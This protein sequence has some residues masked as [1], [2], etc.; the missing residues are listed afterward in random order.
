MKSTRMRQFL[1]AMILLVFAIGTTMISNN[2]EANHPV[3]VEGNNAALFV[4]PTNALN[5]GGVSGDY[6]GDGLVG[7]AEDNDN[8]SDRIF[9]TLTAAFANLNGTGANQ[10]GHVIIV[11]SGRFN[12][13]VTITLTPTTGGV[14]IVE[15]APGVQAN[16][17]AVLQ[18]E[19]RP[20]PN[21]N[22][23][24][25]A[26]TGI[27]INDTN[28]FPSPKSAV[29]RNL[30]IR[31]WQVGVRT[32]GT[33][34]VALDSCRLDSNV[35]HGVLVTGMGCFEATDSIIHAGGMRF[36]APGIGG[37]NPGN[38]ITFQDATFGSLYRNTITGNLGAGISLTAG[39]L[40]T[41]QGNNLFD[42]N[43]GNVVGGMLVA[44]PANQ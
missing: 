43:A 7:T 5:S 13:S 12:E 6:D 11:T 34:R 17:D 16:I 8:A 28:T 30:V 36:P 10:N 41:A 2:V 23:T 15:A 42:N 20:A 18:G 44:P 24:R 32:M 27:T 21:D 19:N 26:G 1:M 38:G 9:G 22:A 40:V 31:N 37:Q 39:N 3:L 4:N 14:M 29:L 35:M 33:A 25:Q